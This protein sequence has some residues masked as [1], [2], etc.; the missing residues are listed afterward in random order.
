MWW[1]LVWVLF[2]GFLKTVT[3][4]QSETQ[5]HTQKSTS[6]KGKTSDNY[7]TVSWKDNYIAG[8]EKETQQSSTSSK[9][10][11]N[12]CKTVCSKKRKRWVGQLS[13]LPQEPQ[14][15]LDTYR[16]SV[17]SDKV[18]K[19][20]FYYYLPVVSSDAVFQKPESKNTL[21]ESNEVNP[22][23]RVSIPQSQKISSATTITQNSAMAR[24]FRTAGLFDIILH[25]LRFDT[26]G[27]FMQAFRAFGHRM[28]NYGYTL[29]VD[30]SVTVQAFPATHVHFPADALQYY[31]HGMNHLYTMGDMVV[32]IWYHPKHRELIVRKTK[33]GSQVTHRWNTLRNMIPFYIVNREN[34][35]LLFSRWFSPNARVARFYQ[36][37]YGRG[38][39][40]K[41]HY[42]NTSDE[43]NI[44]L[45]CRL[46][47]Q[48]F[49]IV[50]PS[51]HSVYTPYAGFIAL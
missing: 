18:Q 32:S 42:Q 20:L 19:I 24:V 43:T 26:P 33:P 48:E 51:D 16:S 8:K 31:T 50:D 22:P 7:K 49:S 11:S 10:K 2:C 13:N 45:T 39:Y 38:V 34:N 5:Q 27:E 35:L 47:H 40:I 4:T 41:L 29:G 12:S 9:G 3:A 17:L 1:L 23:K 44:I 36:H 37:F 30:Y 21:E 15:S 14:K 46:R 28:R 25:Y 6:S